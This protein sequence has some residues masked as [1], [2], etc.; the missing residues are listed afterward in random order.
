MYHDR[1]HCALACASALAGCAGR[2]AGHAACLAQL[3]SGLK[4]KRL[5]DSIVEPAGMFYGDRHGGVRDAYG[6]SWWIATHIEDVP[7]DELE[8]RH[9]IEQR[10]R[11]ATG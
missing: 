3:E 11:A 2:R 10:R 5:F 6:N 7:P 4:W 8:R 9:E 1:S